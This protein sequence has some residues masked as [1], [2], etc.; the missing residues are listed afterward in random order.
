MALRSLGGRISA[1]MIQAGS[2]SEIKG[3][4]THHK[5]STTPFDGDR[6]VLPQSAQR[7]LGVDLDFDDFETSL[8]LTPPT[9]YLL[10]EHTT[11]SFADYSRCVVHC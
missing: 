8:G 7:P 6:T 4:N 3:V 1:T 10:N 9:S 2:G 11:S 5:Y